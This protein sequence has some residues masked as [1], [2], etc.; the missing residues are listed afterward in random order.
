LRRKFHSKKG[1]LQRI[2]RFY[3]FYR[4]FENAK[5]Q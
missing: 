2:S 4:V 1:F 3:R 5:M